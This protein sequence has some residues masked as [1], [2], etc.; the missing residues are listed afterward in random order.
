M[1]FKT[2]DMGFDNVDSSKWTKYL[3]PINLNYQNELFF[4]LNKHF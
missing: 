3:Y 4:K 2:S 1:Y